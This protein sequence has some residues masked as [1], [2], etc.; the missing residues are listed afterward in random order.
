MY[1]NN[2]Y[3]E[4]PYDDQA[5]QEQLDERLYDAVKNDPEFDPT[6]L[7]NF[8]ESIGQDV[9]DANLQE[10]IRDCVEKKDWEALGRKLYYHS[11]AYMEK[12]AEIRLT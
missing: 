8:A 10:F 4:A 1:N 7:G 5:E 9:D 12:V 3:Y 11:W 2:S 6:D